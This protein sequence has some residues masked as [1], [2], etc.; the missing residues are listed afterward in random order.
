MNRFNADGFDSQKDQAVQDAQEK[1]EKELSGQFDT[2]RKLKE[3]E[4]KAE[5]SRLTKEIEILKRSLDEATRQ[6]KEIAV[7]VIE[8]GSQA[9]TQITSES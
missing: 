2:E 5:N 7:K 4:V 3:Q 8:S 9:K 1:L 6:V